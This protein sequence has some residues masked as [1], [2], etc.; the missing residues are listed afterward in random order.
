[1]LSLSLCSPLYQHSSG[2]RGCAGGGCCQIRVCGGVIP[3][4]GDHMDT[5]QH[6]HQVGSLLRLPRARALLHNKGVTLE[7]SKGS[8]VRNRSVAVIIVLKEW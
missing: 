3:R 1:M 6:S 4:A 8:A 2:N 5:Q 7:A